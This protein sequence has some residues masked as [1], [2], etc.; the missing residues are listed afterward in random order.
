MEREP[1]QLDLKRLCDAADEIVKYHQR[2]VLQ[3]RGIVQNVLYDMEHFANI[4]RLL[5]YP[6]HYWTPFNIDFW[7]ARERW[8]GWTDEV[9]DAFV[10]VISIARNI[11]QHWIQS[12]IAKA[13]VLS[14]IR[15]RIS[16][17]GFIE[18]Q[19]CY[20]RQSTDLLREKLKSPWPFNL[21]PD[22]K[23]QSLFR[24]ESTYKHK[25]ARLGD[26]FP[27][28]AAICNAGGFL[29]HEGT[30]QSFK[31]AG[32]EGEYQNAFKTAV[33][34]RIN[35]EL[36]PLDVELTAVRGKGWKMELI[37]QTIQ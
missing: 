12:G 16:T 7:E 32:F 13:N 36:I 2:S 5:P 17:S 6:R 14:G 27:V 9:Y 34:R 26:W 30:E 20:L 23:S 31:D 10:G 37:H 21:L 33:S 22:P 24:D 4:V 18:E 28:I 35:M 8:K 1:A 19:V 29:S 11:N 3:E 25:V 15:L